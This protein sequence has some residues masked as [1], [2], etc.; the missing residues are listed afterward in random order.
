M[1]QGEAHMLSKPL[2]ATLLSFGA[3]ALVL[4]VLYAALWAAH[5]GPWLSDDEALSDLLGMSALFALPSPLLAAVALPLAGWLARRAPRPSGLAFALWCCG[6]LALGTLLLAPAA[7]WALS[8]PR[9]LSDSLVQLWPY[10]LAAFAFSLLLVLP[11]SALW[12]RLAAE[13]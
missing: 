8:G 7:Q 13:T 11:W 2:R 6:L 5:R 10:W 4:A 12:W 9:G 3:S 1:R